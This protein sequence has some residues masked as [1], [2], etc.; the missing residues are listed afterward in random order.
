MTRV[1]SFLAT[2]I[3]SSTLAFAPGCKKDEAQNTETTE[4]A[5]GEETPATPA[6]KPAEGEAA[7]ADEAAADEAA[8][9]E[10]AA[11]EAAADEAVVDEEDEEAAE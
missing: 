6:A 1:T 10:A 11:D 2:L 3:I 8:A 4:P 9:D 7:A 5:A